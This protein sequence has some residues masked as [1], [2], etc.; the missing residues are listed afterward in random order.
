MNAKQEWVDTR[1]VIHALI[2]QG[3]ETR[4]Q[5]EERLARVIRDGMLPVR[6][7]FDADDAPPQHL[8][9]GRGLHLEMHLSDGYAKCRP[10]GAVVPY[11]R[12]RGVSRGG[13]RAAPIVVR[14]VEPRLIYGLQVP[15]EPASKAL[16]VVLTVATAR[17]IEGK[18]EMAALAAPLKHS[19]Q[20]RKQMRM[21]MEERALQY[22]LP[23]FQEA[24]AEGVKPPVRATIELEVRSLGE[25]FTQRIARAALAR[26]PDQLRHPDHR[27]T[28]PKP[29]KQKPIS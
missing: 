13:N 24:H 23:R 15:A 22:M 16:G 27:K 2:H 26:V 20:Q 19:A 7:R 6:G 14:S 28:Y 4:P 3:K 29:I 10:A 5:A 9:M 1:T 17:M 12:V 11:A 18:P 21:E 25:G 8:P